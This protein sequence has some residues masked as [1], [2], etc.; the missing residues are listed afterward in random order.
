MDLGQL[1]SPP[2]LKRG[3]GRDTGVIVRDVRRA[4]GLTQAELGRRTGYSAA[5]VSR[6]ERGI[7]A[8]TVPVLRRF[9]AALTIS[10]QTFGLLPDDAPTTPGAAPLHA[11]A[12]RVS[13][14]ARE[15]GDDPVRR[16]QLL[17]RLA[18]TAA[19]AAGSA[20]VGGVTGSTAEAGTGA[21]FVGRVRDAMLGLA[22]R[23]ADISPQRLPAEL[24]TALQ[25]FHKCRYGRLA[26]GLPQLI[27]AAHTVV[28]DRPDDPA[29]NTL[30]AEIYTL[31]TRMLIKLDDQQL[32]WMA[33][34]RAR[35]IAGA[36]GNAL[37]AAEAARNL[38]VLARKAGWNSQAMSIALTA[39]DDP[40]LV[41]TVQGTP[42]NADC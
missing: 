17:A 30:L 31:T 34:D 38:A 36:G 26:D 27:T 2:L 5:Q 22:P 19:A 10:P 13:G 29:A 9:A 6:Y 33:A 16:R 7:A 4:Q 23:L 12:P 20:A 42:R 25:D 35:V 15:D 40:G 8:F 3:E 41:A 39:A 37:T 28:A 21:L 11:P 32:G 24:A 18:V 14:E 1:R